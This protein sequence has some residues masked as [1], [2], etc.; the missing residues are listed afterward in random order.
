M[1]LIIVSENSLLFFNLGS[2]LR[3]S[4]PTDHIIFSSPIF[5]MALVDSSSFSGRPDMLWVVSFLFYFYMTKICSSA[6]AADEFFPFCT[7][8]SQNLN[9]L[10]LYSEYRIMAM[11]MLVVNFGLN[12]KFHFQIEKW[13]SKLWL[14]TLNKLPLLTYG[15]RLTMLKPHQIRR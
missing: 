2:R 11:M 12:F 6:S 14:K 3:W 5:V 4:I 9:C 10:L 7:D 13:V 15:T 1:H 8:G